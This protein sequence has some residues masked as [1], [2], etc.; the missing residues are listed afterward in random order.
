M[1]AGNHR[2]AA[3]GAEWFMEC[4]LMLS[5]ANLRQPKAAAPDFA[6]Q[7]EISRIADAPMAPRLLDFASCDSLR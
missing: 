6:A 2:H 3:L 5:I 1:P 4:L 7:C